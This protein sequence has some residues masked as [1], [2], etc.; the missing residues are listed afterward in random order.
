MKRY[1]LAWFIVWLILLYLIIKLINLQ[2]NLNSERNEQLK[3]ILDKQQQQ[4]DLLNKNND[5]LVD[6]RDILINTDYTIN[7][8]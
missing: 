1:I 6:I 7:I 8:E 5:I 2:D 3:I 4:I